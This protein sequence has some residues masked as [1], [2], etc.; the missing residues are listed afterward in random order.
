VAA[1]RT[2]ED[3][4]MHSTPWRRASLAAL[5]LAAALLSSCE[6]NSGIGF[7]VGLPTNYGG[8][9]LGMATSNWVGG[10]FWD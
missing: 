1:L 10:P 8:M 4:T 7:S 3:S 9:E 2:L 5:I 6:N